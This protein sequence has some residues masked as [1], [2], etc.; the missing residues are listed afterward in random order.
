MIDAGPPREGSEGDSPSQQPDLPPTSLLICSRDRPDLLGDTVASVL[1]GDHLPTEVVIIDQSRVPH[2]DLVHADAS[3]CE[4]RYRWTRSRGVSR[5]RNEAIQEAGHEVL[6]LT[7][8]D[9]EVTREWFG[10]LVRA[11]VVAGPRS[12]VTGRVLPSATDRSPG[13]VPSTKEDPGPAVYEGRIGEDILYPH[14]MALYANAPREVG[15]FDVRLGGGARFHGAEDNDLCHRLLKAGYRIH[16]VPEAIV[17]HRAWR[18]RRDYLPLRWRYGRGQ[19]A[20]YGKHLDL[21]DRYMLGRL[22]REIFERIRRFVIRAWRQPLGALG[23]AVYLVGLVSGTLEWLLTQRDDR[24]PPVDAR[25]PPVRSPES[26][27]T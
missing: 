20:Y 14:N 7:D 24:S 13:F 4:V 11:L 17:Y 3:A 23:E 27:A 10:T 6:V 19:G 21:R 12:V 16:Y 26:E 22:C 5:A 8:D 18:S 25:E 1:R 15:G 2:P 9:V